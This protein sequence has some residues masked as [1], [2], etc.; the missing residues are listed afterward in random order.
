M[1]DAYD[2]SYSSAELVVEQAYTETHYKS[3]EYAE[4]TGDT[5]FSEIED[6]SWTDITDSF[7]SKGSTVTVDE[8]LQPGTSMTFHFSNTWTAE[9]WSSITS[10]DAGGGAG[11]LGIGGGGSIVDMIFG[12]PGV[13]AA[14]GG[15]VGR[16]KGWI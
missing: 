14:V 16:A 3:V 1:P 12:I 9:E 2:L 11:P 5:E 10:G 13:V 4:G 7:N 6:T 15:L 8:T